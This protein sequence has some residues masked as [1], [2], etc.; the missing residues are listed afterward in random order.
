MEEEKE[1]GVEGRNCAFLSGNFF[2]SHK[3][4]KLKIREGGRGRGEGEG[5]K[6]TLLAFAKTLGIMWI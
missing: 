4:W 3:K 6:A 1:E 5:A 2:L